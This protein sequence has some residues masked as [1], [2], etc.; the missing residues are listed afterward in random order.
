MEC[1]RRSTKRKDKATSKRPKSAVMP[2]SFKLHT[3]V[4]AEKRKLQHEE[5]E[6][7]HL[8]NTQRRIL[9]RKTV[10]DF[11]RFKLIRR[12]TAATR[13]RSLHCNGN[14]SKSRIHM[15]SRPLLSARLATSEMVSNSL[16]RRPQSAKPVLQ[17][18]YRS[19]PDRTTHFKETEVVEKRSTAR[20][21]SSTKKKKKKKTSDRK[22]ELLIPS[23]SAPVLAD[24]QTLPICKKIN[25][26]V[27][28]RNLKLLEEESPI[29]VPP[30]ISR[31]AWGDL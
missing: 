15:E 31:E 17:S 28:M 9:G 18:Q 4:L 27:N 19:T 3:E 10:E 11:A 5:K 25:I 12:E 1:L 24:T 7:A 16:P 8:V 2:V 29:D 22:S 13:S 23:L 30:V 26:V 6:V 14:T 20:S 21:S